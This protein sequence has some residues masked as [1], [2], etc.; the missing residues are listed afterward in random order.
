MSYG[1][2][3]EH[4]IGPTKQGL[5]LRLEDEWAA[6]LDLLPLIHAANPELA[7]TKPCC[8]NDDHQL[9]MLCCSG[10]NPFHLPMECIELNSHLTVVL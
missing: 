10:C 1:L 9:G 5:V 2:E 4:N 8:E 7:A 3:G 6:L